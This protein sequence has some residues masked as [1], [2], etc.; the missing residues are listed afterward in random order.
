MRATRRGHTY[1]WLAELRNMLL[2]KCVELDCDYLLSCDCD[3][4]MKTNTLIRLLAHNEHCVSSLVY[5]GYI[6]NPEKHDSSFS[7][8]EN[9]HLF[10]NCLIFD[11][12]KK[13]Y[14]H[15]RNKRIKEPDKNP[16]GTTIVTHITGACILISKELASKAKYGYFYIGEDEH[17]CRQARMLGYNVLCDVSLL[18]PHIMSKMLL[19]LYLD[20]LMPKVY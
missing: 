9:A 6:H 13:I 15:I 2:A 17:F 16:V 20:G 10:S 8:I 18:N 14:V 12:D 5:N 11:E 3:I 19:K 1:Y 4:L 7:C